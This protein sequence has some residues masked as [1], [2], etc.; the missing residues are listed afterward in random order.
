MQKETLISKPYQHL[1]NAFLDAQNVA[2]ELNEEFIIIYT[3]GIGYEVV[4]TEFK[5]DRLYYHGIGGK[6]CFFDVVEKVLPTK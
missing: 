3:S 1:D 6:K 4:T 5:T 2:N